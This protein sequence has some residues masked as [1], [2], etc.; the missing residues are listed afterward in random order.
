MKVRRKIIVLVYPFMMKILKLTGMRI[1][2]LKN[3]M[4][5]TPFESFYSLKAVLNNGEEISFEQFKNKKII[6]VN[7]AS[8]C[9]FTP[10][11]AALEN[12]YQ[13]NK[14]VVILGLPSNDFGSQEPGNDDEINN[15]C[16]TN[17]GITFPVFKK[18][19]VKGNRKQPVYQ[20]LTDKN[21]NGW[22][23][24]EPKWNFYKYLID[25]EGKLS[26]IFSSAISPLDIKF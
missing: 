8:E 14:T 12:L 18:N 6:I 4:N 25:E 3:E 16:K 13:S 20:W 5:V 7:L 19:H 21:K 24:Q 1:R 11:Y 17:F 26:K 9:A 23:D 15:F 22:N 2:I 10:Q